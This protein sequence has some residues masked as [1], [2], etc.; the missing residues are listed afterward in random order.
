VLSMK[1]LSVAGLGDV[2]QTLLI[3]LA[4]RAMQP[5]A[6]PEIGLNDPAAAAWARRLDADLGPFQAD[7]GTMRGACVRSKWFDAQIA[8]FLRRHPEAVGVSIGCGLNATLARVAREVDI[9]RCDWVDVDLPE[10]LRLRR[11]LEPP[12][13]RRHQLAIEDDHASWVAAVPWAPDRPIVL[14]AEASLI[15]V[16]L[17]VLRRTLARIA[18]RFGSR[19][20]P[21]LFL[22]DFC[23]PL[24]LEQGRSLPALRAT[25]ANFAW[26]LTRAEDLA[27]LDRRYLLQ[28]QFDVLAAS[29]Q[30]WALASLTYRL[31]NGGRLFYGTAAYRV[32]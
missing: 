10:V 11:A 25:R 18:D 30:P 6:F 19:R 9:T 5:D 8:G 20:R 13:P 32:R 4:A 12:A 27:T 24:L 3:P 16:P 15:Y 1:A 22:T 29:G 14:M 31:L 21:A 23:S 17:A 7:T 28:A 26:A 2:A